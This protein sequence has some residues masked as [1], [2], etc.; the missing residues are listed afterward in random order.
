MREAA[1]CHETP[2][3]PTSDL[4]WDL[5]GCQGIPWGFREEFARN[6]PQELSVGSHKIKREANKC[7]HGIPCVGT[8]NR[9]RVRVRVGGCWLGFRLV[10]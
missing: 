10:S 2:L 5:A 6:L 1:R 3:R 7:P 9:T 8:R 4:G